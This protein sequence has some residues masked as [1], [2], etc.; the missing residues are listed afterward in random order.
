LERTKV[1]EENQNLK[2]QLVQL[3]KMV[4]VEKKI[5]QSETERVK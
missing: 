4:A 2:K 1:V 5:R 3:E